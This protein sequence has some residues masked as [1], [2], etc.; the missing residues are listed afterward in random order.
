MENLERGFI[1][2][3]KLLSY[4]TEEDIFK[5]VFEEIPDEFE[6]VTSPFREDNYPGCWFQKGLR[7]DLRFVDFGNMQVVNG[8]KMQNIDCFN[9]VQVYYNLPNF[10]QT[11]DFIYQK[12]IL[13]R[14]IK[15]LQRTKPQQSV[16]RII[17][18]VSIDIEVRNFENRDARYWKQ[19][20]IS[21]QNL[22][23]DGVFPVRRFLVRNTRHG[24]I[25]RRPSKITYAFTNFKEGK[26]KLYSPYENSKK[27]FL[28]DCNEDD[29]GEIDSL[30]PKTNSLII[31]KS[32]KDCRII[33][34][35]GF[36]S[37]WL[38][39]ETMIPSNN[40]LIS[41]CNRAREIIVFFDNDSVGIEAAKRLC[42][43]INTFLP[44]KARYVHLPEELLKRSIT[45]PGD[46]YQK[47]GKL[48]IENFL[49]KNL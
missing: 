6:Y 31:S 27:K 30:K 14:D 15:K 1:D 40:T 4:V 18:R 36:D 9:A 35:F 17:K 22:I 13:G 29:I 11:L 39:G 26:K 44:G 3:E 24:D 43:L 48:H 38:Q 7:G 20:G 37:V 45:D 2:K 19:F 25:L 12:L 16:P 34:N 23:D 41:L 21:R 28:T 47:M 49:N 33:K 10:Y 42:E 46:M 32:Y 8:I 5:L